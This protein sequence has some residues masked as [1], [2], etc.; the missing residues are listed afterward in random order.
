MKK[1]LWRPE[2]A[3]Q[4]Q[5]LLSPPLSASAPARFSASLSRLAGF[6]AHAGALRALHEA[7]LHPSRVCGSS[8]GSIISALYAGGVQER[9][10]PIAG[11]T[12]RSA[13][14][15]PLS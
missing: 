13:L 1:E 10:A 5:R 3:C 8:S 15:A 7:G 9:R 11:S 14:T 6:Y 2:L 12:V 4:R